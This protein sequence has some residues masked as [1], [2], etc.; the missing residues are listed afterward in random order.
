MSFRSGDF[1]QCYRGHHRHRPTSTI[2]YLVYI[3]KEKSPHALTRKR[4]LVHVL[5]GLKER[6]KANIECTEQADDR[7]KFRPL[8]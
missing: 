8:L 1:G 2:F 5:L 4:Q 6:L 3:W 7:L